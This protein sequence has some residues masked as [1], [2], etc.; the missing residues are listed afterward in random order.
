MRLAAAWT[1]QGFIDWNGINFNGRHQVHPRIIGPI[2]FSNA[3]LPGWANPENESVVDLRQRG[4]DARPYGPLPRRWI[5]YKGMYRNG[6]Q[7]ILAYAV[8]NVEIL[9]LPGLETDPAHADRPIFTRTLEI[10][11]APYDLT[12]RV[13]PAATAVCLAGGGQAHLLERDGCT[14][15]RV[16]RSD[17]SRRLKV[18]MSN[19]AA[20]DLQSH[21][22]SSAAPTA[23]APLTHGGPRR[24]PEIVRNQDIPGLDDRPL[25]VDTLTIPTDNPWLCQMRPSGFDFMPGGREAALCTWDGDVWSVAGIDTPGRGLTCAESRRDCSS[26]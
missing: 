6:D 24:W 22:K 7:V 9:E 12:M 4:R 25:A 16:P 26:H 5:H 17:S 19:L 15:L 13:G 11:P 14:F 3:D 2:Q 20:N 23:L 18:L 8:G 1:G 10:G 21:A